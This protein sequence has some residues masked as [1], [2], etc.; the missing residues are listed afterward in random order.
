[1]QIKLRN[2]G[3]I[4]ESAIALDGLTVITGKNNSGKTTVG[5]TLY[6]LL[7]A[8]S[9]LSRK[10]QIDRNSYISKQL[11]TVKELLLQ[12]VHIRSIAEPESSLSDYPALSAILFRSIVEEGPGK[13][14]EDLAHELYG[15]L[16]SVGDMERAMEP[17]KIKHRVRRFDEESQTWAIKEVSL[18]APLEE[19]R[20]KAL[21]VLERLFADLEKDA[22]LSDYARESIN[23]TLRMEFGGQIQDRKSVV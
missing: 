8:T 16:Q 6:A 9:N 7:E 19:Q 12:G 4:R 13:G 21:D 20:R 5:K 23:Q 15:E 22:D 11:Y 18:G 14:L 3:I 10:A 17:F 2:I 1:M